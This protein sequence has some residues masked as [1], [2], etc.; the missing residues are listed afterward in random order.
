M[1]VINIL[2]VELRGQKEKGK[3]GKTHHGLKP[4]REEGGGGE[5]DA[6]RQQTNDRDGGGPQSASTGAERSECLGGHR[7]LTDELC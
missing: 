4:V 7:D 2:N 3:K 1:Q 6:N 5:G